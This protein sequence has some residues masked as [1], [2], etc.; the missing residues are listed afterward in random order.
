MYYIHCIIVTKTDNLKTPNNDPT[1][2]KKS[3]KTPTEKGKQT[4]TDIYEA[5][6]E[7]N[8]KRSPR[9]AVEFMMTK[10]KAYANRYRINDNRANKENKNKIHHNN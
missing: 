9:E 5:I 4:T 2:K 1:K 6:K 8:A 10:T 3:N 7:R